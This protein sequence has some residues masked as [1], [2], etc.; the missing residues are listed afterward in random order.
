MYR[1][2]LIT[3]KRH[4]STNDVYINLDSNFSE[5]QQLLYFWTLNSKLDLT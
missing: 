2:I 3:Y 5:Q 4:D 1:L